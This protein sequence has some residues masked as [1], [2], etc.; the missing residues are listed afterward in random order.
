MSADQPV[1]MTREQFSHL[2]DLLTATHA[3]TKHLQRLQQVA[4][5]IDRCDGLL[6]EH[7]RTWIRAMDG[8]NTENLGDEFLMDLAKAT[9]AGDL[10]EE[11]RRQVNAPAPHNTDDWATLRPHLVNHFLSACEDVKL[12]ALLES[13]K[14]RTGESTA[15]F[16]RR[17]RSD[18]ARAYTGERSAT[19]EERVVASF[20]RGFVDVAFARRLFRKDRIKTLAEAIREALELEAQ[21]ERM[22]QMLRS[23]GEEP[24][25]VG[26]VDATGR[27]LSVLEGM[28][29]QLAKVEVATRPSKEAATPTKQDQPQQQAPQPSQKKKPHPNHRWSARGQPIC[30]NCGQEGHFS[31]DCGGPRAGPPPGGQ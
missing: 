13:I 20:L 8:W 9:A 5:G 29:K 22:E 25:E 7:V 1:V 26:G 12:Q 14:Q 16:I 3:E 6:P 19:E 27:L 18:A 15:A 31:R 21:R 11:I 4:R 17:F 10:L 30:Y 28:Q 2:G 24:M 23:R